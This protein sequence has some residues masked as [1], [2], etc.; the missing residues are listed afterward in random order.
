MICNPC[1]DREILLFRTFF[2][3]CLFLGLYLEMCD[4]KS[5]NRPFCGVKTWNAPYTSRENANWVPLLF[6]GVMLCT[7]DM[8]RPTYVSMIINKMSV[9]D[10]PQTI[11]KHDSKVHGAKIGPVCG[12]QDPGGPYV[13]PMNLAIWEPP[14]WLGLVH[15]TTWTVLCNISRSNDLIIFITGR[16][17]G[18][19]VVSLLLVGSSFNSD[20]TLCTSFFLLTG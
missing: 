16:E 9:S 2:S 3:W 17:F 8:C 4:T 6:A 19:T 10:R 15:G 7:H 1:R 11:S 5:W 14:Y 18:N 20:N 12:R 13:G